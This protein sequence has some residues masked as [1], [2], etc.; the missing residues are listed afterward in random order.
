MPRRLAALVLALLAGPAARG[1]IVG[2]GDGAGTRVAPA[3][4]PGFVHVGQRGELTAIYLGRGWMLTAAHVAPGDVVV[5]GVSYTFVPG[6]QLPLAR[7]APTAP[8]PDLALFRVDPSPELPPLALASRAPAV[9]ADVVMV[10]FGRDRGEAIRWRGLRGYAWAPHH[11]MR[12]GTNRVHESGLEVETHGLRTPAFSTQF[13]A[14]GTA[15]EAQ[16]SHGDSG[17]AVFA[18]GPQGWELAGILLSV[19]QYEGQPG[20]AA[21]YGNQTFAADLSAYRAEILARL[22][23]PPPPP[24]PEPVAPSRGD[25]RPAGTEPKS[26]AR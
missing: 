24:R 15:Y 12:W 10:G 17:G 22:A 1:V 25:Q 2:P 7:P 19:T 21:L 20:S 4:D 5:A 8:P 13:N 11:V 23:A 26:P 6:S 18:R 14:V 3:D 9:G 16:A